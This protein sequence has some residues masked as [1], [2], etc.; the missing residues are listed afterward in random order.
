MKVTMWTSDL[1]SFLFISTNLLGFT[2]I[3]LFFL[4]YSSF[5]EYTLCF[6]VNYIFA[7]NFVLPKLK[8]VTPAFPWFVLTYILFPLLL[9]S[10]FLDIA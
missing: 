10:T 1:M 2:D 4:V 9:F 6:L 8:I 3:Y 5:I 7:L